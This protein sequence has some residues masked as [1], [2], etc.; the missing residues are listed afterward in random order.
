MNEIVKN[1]GW[2]FGLVVF[3]IF[4]LDAIDL[5]LFSTFFS[6]MIF[7]FFILRLKLETNV[8][9]I[10]I[11]CFLMGIIIDVF[12]DTIG[13]NTAALLVVGITRSYYLSII[14]ARD[15]FESTLYLNFF[16]LGIVRFLLYFGLSVMTHHLMFF[17]LEEFSLVNF[18]SLLFKSVVNTAFALLIL[19]FLQYLLIPKK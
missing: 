19:I 1:I 9:R 3:Q 7:S 18:F 13:L 8:I 17:L 10:L 12:R 11:Y 4:I 16:T 14:S 5:G 6:P 2:F 15:D